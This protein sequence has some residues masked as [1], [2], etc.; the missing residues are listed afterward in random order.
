MNYFNHEIIDEGLYRLILPGRVFAYLAVGKE[1]AA[2]IDTGFGIGSLK[3]Y[4]HTI[5]DRPLTVILTHGHYDHAGGAG[6]FS[7][8]CI[9][10]DDIALALR[11]AKREVR[12]SALQ[13]MSFE[14]KD[15]VPDLEEGQIRTFVPDQVFDLGGSSIV[16]LAMPGHTR[17]SHAVLFREKRIVLFGDACNSAAFM[18]LNECTTIREYRESLIRFKNKYEDEYD[19][20]LYSHPHNYGDKTIL[21]ESIALCEDI[22]EGRDDSLLNGERDGHPV[23]IAKAVDETMKRKDGGTANILYRKDKIR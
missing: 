13:G 6:E 15:I 12:I 7:H 19:S 21:D 16:M 3:E 11:G 8:V 17:G 10:K 5:M 23:F 14:E 9:H 2:L 4:V 1:K 18:Q 20:V 22:I